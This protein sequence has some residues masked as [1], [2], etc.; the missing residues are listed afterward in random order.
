MQSVNRVANWKGKVCGDRSQ[1]VWGIIPGDGTFNG[2]LGADTTAKQFAQARPAVDI[3]RHMWHTVA[4]SPDNFK[5]LNI[6]LACGHMQD[7]DPMARLEI[8]INRKRNMRRTFRVW[9][10]AQM[11]LGAR[12]RAA[13]ITFAY[14]ECQTS[15]HNTE[16]L[17]GMHKML[18][19][20]AVLIFKDLVNFPDYRFVTLSNTTL[21]WSG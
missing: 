14:T 4:H 12:S 5:S 21:L 20:G 13:N 18:Q 7:M 16:A 11:Q 10:R 15:E 6:Y 1:P 8:G 2:S 9:H 19:P 3:S 17:E